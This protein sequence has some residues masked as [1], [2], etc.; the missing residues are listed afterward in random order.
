LITAVILGDR[1]AFLAKRLLI[2]SQKIV[3][4]LK[5]AGIKNK[6]V[7]WQSVITFKGKAKSFPYEGG[8]VNGRN[9]GGLHIKRQTDSAIGNKMRPK[10]YC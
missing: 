3:N 10:P 9:R 2:R 7:R 1:N 6:K 4:G 8:W 5:R